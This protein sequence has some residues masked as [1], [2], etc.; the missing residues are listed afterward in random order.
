MDSLPKIS[1]ITPSYNQGPFIEATIQSV[2]SQ[3]YP[4]VEYIIVDGGST[5][6]TLSVIDR[7]RDKIHLVISEKDN[8]QS[9]AINKGFR[10]ATGDLVG[11]INSDDILYP[12]CAE[13]IADLYRR[14][15]DGSIYYGASLDFIDKAG[16]PFARRMHKIPDKNHLLNTC[17]EVFQQ[18]SFYRAACLE[19]AGYLDESLYYC[20]DLDVWLRL[21]DLGNIYYHEGE[22]LAAF[23]IWE[24]TKT[25]L[26]GIA[27][28]KDTLETL[29][30]YGARKISPAK[31]HLYYM[32][33]RIY[34][35]R[36]KRML[37][38]K[39]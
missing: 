11:W 9:D 10:R 27:F 18:G 24:S 37:H 17:Y 36:L 6:N 30:R 3:A 22:P 12:D 20:M 34:G 38:L 2:L 33:F 29:D 21:L 31:M 4:R 14:H 1:I 39:K 26:A 32:L 25:S 13:K 7:Y 8:G 15:P 5:D 28:L 19:K 16:R 23:R 35:G